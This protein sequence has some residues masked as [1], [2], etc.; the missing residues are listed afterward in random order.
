MRIWIPKLFR[1]DAEQET[2]AAAPPAASPP[3]ARDVRESVIDSVPVTYMESRIPEVD[4]AF[5]Y[6]HLD[7]R[8][9]VDPEHFR[10][11]I[12]HTV[13]SEDIE[14]RVA[15]LAADEQS[16]RQRAATVRQHR[17]DLAAGDASL[18][19]LRERQERSEAVVGETEAR[20]ERADEALP[21]H[22]MGASYSH[23]LMFLVAG[24]L[25]IFGDVVM[26]RKIVSDALRLTGHKFFGVLD[27]SWIFA[28]GLAMLSIV[29]KPAYDRLVEKPYWAGREKRFV[30]VICLLAL[31]SVGTLWVLG[32]FRAESYS[33]QRRV[34]MVDGNDRLTDEQKLAEIGVIEERML[35][36]RL[37]AWSFV[38]SGI[39][40]AA[41][42]AVTLSIGVRYAREIRHVRRPALKQREELSRALTSARATRDGVAADIASRGVEMERLRALTADEP[43]AP[44][45]DELADTL[46]AERRELQQR[47]VGVRQRRLRSLYDDGYELA[48]VVPPPV[49]PQERPRRKRPRPFVA[50][51]R[52]IREMALTPDTL[53]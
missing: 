34:A 48:A 46:A 14:R 31:M 51:R 8:R 44:A 47:F 22:R 16:L 23:A 18:R 36:S 40:F 37:A 27:E 3:S 10:G 35:N 42:G 7:G 5:G 17:A 39:L 38:L 41:A 26:T 1:R 15:E 12:D 19:D 4:S 24:A 13:E 25:F 2:A 6:G 33:D 30:S 53:N 52:A 50:L 20:L 9:G 43:S 29:L 32:E 28:A 49:E 11:F 45:L 21:G